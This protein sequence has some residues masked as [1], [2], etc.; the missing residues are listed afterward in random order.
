MFTATLGRFLALAGHAVGVPGLV[1]S[2]C[3]RAGAE[4]GTLAVGTP[5]TGARTSG[6]PTTAVTHT[7]DVIDCSLAGPI[8][9]CPCDIFAPGRCL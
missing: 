9:L 8:L 6:E 2:R 1:R 7:R 5:L 4:A 3:G